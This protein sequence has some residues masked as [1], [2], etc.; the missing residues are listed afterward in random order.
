MGRGTKWS[1]KTFDFYLR[2]TKLIAR[3]F[4]SNENEIGVGKKMSISI[5]LG[6]SNHSDQIL[7]NLTQNSEKKP[8]QQQQHRTT[9]QVG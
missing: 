2:N 6:W 5:I 8:Q 3:T 9:K 7:R 1:K 4:T